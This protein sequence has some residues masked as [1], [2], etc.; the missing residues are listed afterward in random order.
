VGDVQD[1]HT[2]HWHAATVFEHGERT[3]VLALLP[4]VMT[5]VDMIPDDAGTWKYH[6]HVDSHNFAGMTAQYTVLGTTPTPSLNGT[7]WQY[8]IAAEETFWNYTPN[9]APPA[10]GATWTQP[11]PNRI[12]VLYKK[13][14]YT[15]YLDETFQ[16]KSK[17]ACYNSSRSLVPVAS[18]YS[19]KGI[20][21]PIIRAQVG[22]TIV[23]TFKNLVSSGNASYSLHP[24]AVFYA[25]TSEGSGAA[26]GVAPGANRTY[27]W[28]VNDRAGPSGTDSSILWLY[29]SHINSGKRFGMS[30][31]DLFQGQILQVVWLAPFSLQQKE[32]QLVPPI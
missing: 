10:S 11:G 7:I 15:Q 14:V 9:A 8:Y 17:Q 29:H 25:S 19:H 32:W 31:C 6:C 5:E 13:V 30:C 4:S 3:D 20:L 24:H 21:G 27:T 18:L 2:P 23:V 28:Y 22:D 12:G 26:A 1:V 16:T